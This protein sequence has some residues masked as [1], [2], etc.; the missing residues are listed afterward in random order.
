MDISVIKRKRG[1]HTLR[2]IY[3]IFE[4]SI[5]DEGVIWN[6]H[7]INREIVLWYN[8]KNKNLLVRDSI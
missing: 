4:N 5:L 1:T 2:Y 3:G 8:N 6:Q 7:H